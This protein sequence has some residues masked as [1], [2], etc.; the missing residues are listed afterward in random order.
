MN[1]KKIKNLDIA[2]RQF[3][4]ATENTQELDYS[5]WV[6]FIMNHVDYYV[7]KEDTIEGKE[8]L[9]NVDKIPESFRTRVL[10]AYNKRTACAEFDTK[11]GLYNVLVTFRSEYNRIGITF[12]KIPT[13]GDIKI[14]LKMANH[15]DAFLLNNGTEIIDEGIVE[16]LE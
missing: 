11:K 7:W 6:E 12:E 9:S 16:Q 14:F 8:I 2:K 10:K 4:F 1:L 3:D 15:L 13:I 5:K